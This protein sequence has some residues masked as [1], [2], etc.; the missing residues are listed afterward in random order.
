M[1]SCCKKFSASL[2][3]FH[4]IHILLQ[5]SADVHA[6]SMLDGYQKQ[7]NAWE[8]VLLGLLPGI[9]SCWTRP[10]LVVCWALV[11]T[12]S[13]CVAV[14]KCKNATLSPSMPL[15]QLSACYPAWT[16][17]FNVHAPHPSA[18]TVWRFD[19]GLQCRSCGNKTQSSVVCRDWKRSELCLWAPPLRLWFWA[20][21]GDG[22][23][24]LLTGH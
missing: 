4:S 13:V 12:P 8:S 7:Q 5:P 17:D 9:T 21:L 2:Q 11:A 22:P 15:A 1:I 3:G 19:L 23:L 10:S 20:A 14:S 24:L 16:L 6:G 18:S